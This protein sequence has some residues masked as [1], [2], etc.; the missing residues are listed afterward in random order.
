MEIVED[1]SGYF[2]YSIGELFRTQQGLFFISDKP[3]SAIYLMPLGKTN[4]VDKIDFSK[5][6]D[7]D[8]NRNCYKNYNPN[9]I[10]FEYSCGFQTEEESFQ[11]ILDKHGITEP[12][13]VYKF[14]EEE[15]AIYTSTCQ[16][17]NKQTAEKIIFY[18]ENAELLIPIEC[19]FNE[20]GEHISKQEYGQILIKRLCDQLRQKFLDD[21]L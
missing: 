2:L 4:G 16:Q 14:I 17:S 10:D 21:K 6:V 8:I 1:F 13:Y 5:I 15:E 7:Y 18:I 9:H 11:S 19:F 20:K 12:Q 3:Q